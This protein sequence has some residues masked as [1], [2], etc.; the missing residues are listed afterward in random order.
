MVPTWI[1][2]RREKSMMTNIITAY[3]TLSQFILAHESHPVVRLLNFFF[4]GRIAA[5][6]G[7]LY[8]SVG[9]LIAYQHGDLLI[10]IPCLAAI[11]C[12]TALFIR[13]S[14]GCKRKFALA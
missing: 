7:G 3:G 13:A 9:A 14:Y 8:N 12:N 5:I 1:I 2:K 6:A 10:A 11:A 4:F